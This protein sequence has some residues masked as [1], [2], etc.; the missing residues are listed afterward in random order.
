MK[1]VYLVRHGQSEANAARI[2]AG[3]RLDVDLTDAGRNQAIEVGK[4]LKKKNIEL[5]ISSPQKRALETARIIA[6]QIGYKSENILT[7]Q[8]FA[9][10]DLG[11]LTGKPHDEVQLWFS[12]GQTPPGGESSKAMHDRV[13][14]GLEWLKLLDA[15]TPF[16]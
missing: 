11:T 8:R 2:T 9:E 6:G 13:V 16:C 14:E 5:I 10:R 1:T 12:M 3:G 4:I 7:D 15:A